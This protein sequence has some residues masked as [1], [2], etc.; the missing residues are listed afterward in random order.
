LAYP[1]AVSRVEVAIP[2]VTSSAFL[3]IGG[4]VSLVVAARIESLYRDWLRQANA[5]DEHLPLVVRP[6]VI[7]EMAAWS[8]DAGQSL[9]VVA[10]P[11]I[12]FLL[13]VDEGLGTAASVTY[14]VAVL[15]GLAVLIC[16][17]VAKRP[18]GYARHTRLKIFSPMMDVGL[19]LNV[20]AGGLAVLLSS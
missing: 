20:V 10:A 7:G 2:F 4:F 9:G 3:L 17:L 1:V 15:A 5:H 19:G 13:L 12:G 8:M 14:I 11:A 18:E 6:E 16:F